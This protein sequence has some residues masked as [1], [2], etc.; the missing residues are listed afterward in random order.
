MRQ[1]HITCNVDVRCWFAFLSTSSKAIMTSCLAST[2]NTFTRVELALHLL[3]CQAMGYIAQLLGH[4]FNDLQWTQAPE[5]Q[6]LRSQG[7]NVPQ[8]THD[9]ETTGLCIC[10]NFA[11]F[12]SSSLSL[13]SA[14][15]EKRKFRDGGYGIMTGQD[16]SNLTR[17]RFLLDIIEHILTKYLLAR[18][19]D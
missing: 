10:E 4:T 1:L 2:T 13:T 18:Q 17:L 3:E 19:K 11:S 12:P 16:E 9:R 5:L 15:L 8:R 6:G 14:G 7:L